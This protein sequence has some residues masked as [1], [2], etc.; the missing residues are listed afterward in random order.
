MIDESYMKI[1]PDDWR[2]LLGDIEQLRKERD[3]LRQQVETIKN[4]FEGC[5]Y[6]CEPVGE[7]NKKLLEER[8]EA[9]RKY[10]EAGYSYKSR[11]HISAHGLAEIQGWDCY[12]EGWDC[13]KKET[14]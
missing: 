10:C 1:H 9:R 4:G 6:A 14:L 5:C 3:E 2:Q 7:M 8:D 13:L 11:I 12:K